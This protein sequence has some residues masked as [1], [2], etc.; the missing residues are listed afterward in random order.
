MSRRLTGIMAGL[1]LALGASGMGYAFAASN[2]APSSA[3]GSG[4]G[5]IS[6]YTVT[7][8]GYSLNA[9]TPTN[10]DAVTFTLSPPTA[11]RLT[12]Q[13]TSGGPSDACANT[14]GS[15]FCDTTSPQASLAGADQ[16][17]VLAVQ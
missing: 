16:L 13:L 1:A 2:A 8:I 17:T 11:A 9:T 14:A 6:G 5:P 10:L 4:S 7:S 12:V 3:A 15:V